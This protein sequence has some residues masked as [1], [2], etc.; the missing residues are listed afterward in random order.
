MVAH[1]RTTTR[2]KV[3]ILVVWLVSAFITIPLLKVTELHQGYCTEHWK[4][5]S[6]ENAYWISVFVVQL[7]LPM[8]YI[9]GVYAIIIYSVRTSHSQFELV[10]LHNDMQQQRQ[11]Q[12]RQS[13]VVV[14]NKNSVHTKV[15]EEPTTNNICKVSTKACSDTTQDNNNTYNSTSIDKNKSNKQDISSNGTPK[16]KHRL[17]AFLPQQASDGASVSGTPILQRM[18]NYANTNKPSSN[19]NHNINGTAN[20]D[21]TADDSSNLIEKLPKTKNVETKKRRMSLGRG[22]RANQ[23]NVKRRKKQQNKLLK[24]SVSLVIAYGV[25][26]TP[27][28]AVYFAQKFGTLRMQPYA[29]FFFIVSNLLMSVNS[30]INPCIYGTLND[31]MKKSILKLFTCSK[32]KSTSHGNDSS[33]S[34]GFFSQT[35]SSLGESIRRRFKM[36]NTTSTASSSTTS[37]NDSLNRGTKTTATSKGRLTRRAT[38]VSEC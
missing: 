8:L 25:C 15:V 27:Q 21:I 28:H 7:P 19:N 37:E 38:V 36:Q 12:E 26:V 24:M 5:P 20:G 4:D 22:R 30:A 33:M 3:L 32:Q 34:S 29:A 17:G 23:K 31:E 10:K 2:T 16:E 18:R 35:F 6:I 11:Q 1:R 9:C 13:V 14:D